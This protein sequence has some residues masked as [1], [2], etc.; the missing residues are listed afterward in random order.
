VH[1]PRVS[2]QTHR[3]PK[4]GPRMCVSSPRTRLGRP[5]GCCFFGLFDRS[6]RNG[7]AVSVWVSPLEMPLNSR[8]VSSPRPVAEPR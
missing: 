8:P 5:A 1:G 2:A 6:D 3:C 4:F 7:P